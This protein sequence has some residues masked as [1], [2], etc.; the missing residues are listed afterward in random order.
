MFGN[1]AQNWQEISFLLQ[2]HFKGRTFTIFLKICK[3]DQNIFYRMVV[4]CYCDPSQKIA[5][6]IFIVLGW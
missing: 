3:V 6:K 2:N 5:N 4:N 1:L